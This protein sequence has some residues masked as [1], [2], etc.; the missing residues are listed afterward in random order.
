MGLLLLKLTVT[1]MLMAIVSLAA[2]KWGNLVAGILAGMP[3]TSAP[4]LIYM[5]IEQ[6]IPFAKQAANG[7]LNGLAAIVGTYI[8]YHVAS[9]FLRPLFSSI[10]SLTIYFVMSKFIFDINIEF[11]SIFAILVG[12]CALLCATRGK[13]APIEGVKSPL[14]LMARI[15][16]TTSLVVLVT[17]FADRLGA[18]LS[19]ALSPIPVIAWPLTVF[20]HIHGGRTEAVVIIR[21]NAISGFGILAFYLVVGYGLSSL[22]PSL[23]FLLAIT[24]AMIV[25]GLF[26]VAHCNRGRKP[27][28]RFSS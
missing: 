9:I 8:S 24:A 2:K 12:N 26:L 11:L 19:G 7:S 21:G 1:P 20:A 25:P 5:A 23:T 16:A 10:I 6:G 18:E 4:I 17:G 28:E 22:D 27:S 13:L 15:V 3:L 14:N